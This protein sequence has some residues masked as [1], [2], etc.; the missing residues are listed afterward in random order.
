MPNR[1]HYSS[2]LLFLF[3]CLAPTTV[4]CQ[5]TGQ[6]LPES[7]DDP[8]PVG[9][10]SP[11]EVPLP[12]SEQ[13]PETETGLTP[14][15]AV[16]LTPQ[17]VNDVEYVG[18]PLPEGLSALTLKLQI[19]LDQ[20]GMSPGVID[21]ING[22]NVAKAIAGAEV[23]AGLPVD[24]SLDEEIWGRLPHDTPIL[25]D[26]VITAED[27]A[28]PFLPEIPSDFAEMAK[29][30][31]ISYTDPLEM[32]G[33]RFHMDVDLLK[34]LNPDADFNR[35]GTQIIVAAANI[36]TAT[37]PVATLIADKANAQ[38]RGYD[39]D[40]KLTVAY[41]ATI[42]SNELPSPSG[43]HFVNAVAK[44]AAYYYDPQI[45]FQQGGNTE[46]LTIPPGPNNPIGTTWID[47][48]EPTYGIHGTPEPSRIDKTFS[49]GCVRLTNWD[50]E[51]LA[52]LVEKG[53]PVTF[54]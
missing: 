12:S 20:V 44:N 46:K 8:L 15:P 18:G 9:P 3:V 42:G 40:G 32:L 51:E 54:H 38:L 52:G 2:T 6:V 41:P 47:L 48:S 27:V 36:Y 35:A 21:G 4:Y 22:R 1:P 11:T 26:Y 33:E 23:I 53:V 7:I 24:G 50:V 25:V 14:P 5:E 31:Q 28:G 19:I 17:A 45:N 49:H 37:D 16:L 34:L 29:L 43:T 39:K 30:D 13:S 10:L